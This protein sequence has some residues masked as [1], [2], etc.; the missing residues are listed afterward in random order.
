[1]KWNNLLVV[2]KKPSPVLISIFLFLL[3]FGLRIWQNTNTPP[4][5]YWEEVAIGYDAYSIWE[6]GQDH[7]GNF[8]PLVA[9]PSFGDFKPPL[10]FYLTAPSV[11]IFGLNTL[12]VRLPAVIFSSL[13]VWLIYWLARRWFN[14]DVA[15]WSGLLLAV[16]PWSWQVGRVGF[17]VNLG[18]SLLLAGVLV[19]VKSMEMWQQH[20]AHFHTKNL[21]Q[22]FSQQNI[23]IFAWLG[24][25]AVLMGLSMYSYH[26][27][28]LLAPLFTLAVII[29]QLNLRLIDR[30]I[31]RFRPATNQTKQS[32][33]TDWQKWI[34]SLKQRLIWPGW[35]PWLVAGLI[36]LVIVWPLL[37]SFAKPEINQRWQETSIFV[38]SEPVLES[39]KLRELSGNTLLS[40][41]VFH[42]YL[43]WGKEVAASYLSHFSPQFL[44]GRGDVNPRHTSQY[45]GALYPFEIILLIAGVAAAGQLARRRHHLT[46][47]TT[48][49]LLSPFAAALTLATPH[50]LRALPLAAWLSIWSGLGITSILDEV[51]QRINQS[52]KNRF[53]A[54]QILSLLNIITAVILLISW[55]IL[56][57]YFRYQYRVEFAN[58]WQYGYQELVASVNHHLQ[59]GETAYISRRVGR[60]IMYFL[61]Y[62]RIDPKLVQATN[63]HLPQDQQELLSFGPWQFGE[64]SAGRPG[65]YAWPAK[66]DLTPG[67]TILDEIQDLDGKIIWVVARQTSVQ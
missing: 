17:E 65:L 6:T 35:L 39:N 55:L 37:I 50:G 44:F 36:G 46:L 67:L 34:V 21:R 57:M 22:I 59:P 2:F 20:L 24:L 15:W 5:P 48:L 38:K 16:Q 28:R 64:Y 14:H 29:S 53:K 10:Y 26:A 41:V 47:L 52:V 63:D 32:K 42:R 7:H 23:S 54:H 19:L 13:N 40:R 61:F 60:P 12:A 1:M 51:N 4:S 27:C 11:A 43:F 49:T 25:A 18:T 56:W 30:S 8:L 33:I 9:F 31:S 62:N 58:Q 45:F 66:P 3:A